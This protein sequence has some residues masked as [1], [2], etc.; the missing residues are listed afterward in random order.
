MRE[1]RL[2]CVTSS[3]EIGGAE[4]YLAMLLKGLARAGVEVVVAHPG[5][6]PM[7]EQYRAAAART[8]ALDASSVFA[9]RTVRRL[10]S[11]MREER[12]QLVHTH[13]WN[14]DVLGGLAARQAGLPAV[15]TVYGAYH[16]P[17]GVAGLRGLRRRAL[18]R[19]YRA[20]YA[21]FDRVI[22]LS[23][24]IRKDLIERAGIRAPGAAIETIYPGFEPEGPLPDGLGAGH[25]GA[26]R[27]IVS[28]GNLFPIKGQEWL[29][30]AMPRVLE[31]L[32]GTTCA[33]IGD[34]PER[35]RLESLAAELGL[36]DRVAFLGT[37]ANP[38][39]RVSRAGVFVLP[40]VSEGLPLAI[41]E[42]WRLGVPVVASK[43]GGIPEAV[44]DGRSGLLVPPR[45]PARLADALVAVLSDSGLAR[46]LAEAGREAVRVRFAFDAML[47]RTIAL[48]A[49]VL[50]ARR[51]RA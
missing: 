21:R 45:D 51:A 48:Y 28:V 2:F 31:R 16:L 25:T 37:V 6:G 12:A 23:E 13:L 39:E 20:I 41:L 30:R 4:R 22:A 3:S 49:R 24:Y 43:A 8:R 10:A 15:S 11:W 19:A 40:S 27:S 5:G 14:A 29:L 26:P 36:G 1:L 38:L 46:R 17:I 42:A 32:P 9:P 7:A 47:D 34:G 35:G 44:E 18:S 33:L 50:D